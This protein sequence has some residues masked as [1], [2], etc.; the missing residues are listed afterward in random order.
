M[1]LGCHV[2]MADS[3]DKAVDRAEALGCD[4]FQIFTRSPRMWK[5][6]E[7]TEKEVIEFKEKRKKTRINPVFSHMPYLPNLSSSNMQTYQ[8]SVETLKLELTRCNLLEI[9]YLVTHLGSHLGKGLESGIDQIVKAIETAIDSVSNAP[10]ILLENTSGKTNEVGSTFEE[11]NTII[12]NVSIERIGVC[13]DTCHAYARGYDISTIIGI[14]ST[15][16]KIEETIGFDR[17]KLVHLNDSKGE[18]GSRKDR[19]NHIGLGYIG[20][21]G[22]RNLLGSNFISKPLI[23]ETPV[24]NIRSD[25]DNLYKVREL[26]A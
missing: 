21:D 3:V 20:E 26:A 8:K 15:I 5:H 24:D 25:K 12:E 11:I 1:K 14:S 9:P 2:S 23:L 7:F 10:F 4:V 19:H 18:L 17:V 6:R 13:F 16:Q 22:F